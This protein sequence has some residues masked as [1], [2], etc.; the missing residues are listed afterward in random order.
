MEVKLLVLTIAKY[1]NAIMKKIFLILFTFTS[2]FS[3]GQFGSNPT[4]GNANWNSHFLG[5]IT[6]DRGIVAGTFTDTTAVNAITAPANIKG[7]PFIIV[8][9]SS[10]GKM[11]RRNLATTM[12]VEITTGGSATVP[13]N[14]LLNATG[15][16]NIDISAY[17]QTWNWSG[18][19]LQTDGL[20]LK[21]LKTANNGNGIGHSLFKVY[22]EGG[23]TTGF[24]TTVAAIITAKGFDVTN[25][26][27]YGLIVGAYHG[28][29]PGT[30]IAAKFVA[31]PAGGSTAYAVLVPADSG[32]VHIGGIGA[33]NNLYL[34]GLF[35]YQDGTQAAGYVLTSDL[36]G[37]ASWQPV[38]AADRF[39]VEDNIATQDR[40]FTG[41]AGTY[42]FEISEVKD[43]TLEANRVWLQA[44]GA[45]N[46]FRM[47][48]DSISF[49]LEKGKLSIDSLRRT[50][51]MTNMQ[52]VIRDSVG[53]GVYGIPVTALGLQAPWSM[54]A[55][56]S[57]PNANGATFSANVL[58]LQ[59]ASTSFGG[60]VNTTTQSFSGAKTFTN[61]I[62][63]AAGGAY[64]SGLLKT[65]LAS[66]IVDAGDFNS[67]GNGTWFRT[68]DGNN[69]GYFDNDA[70]TAFFGFN[71][72]VPTA[73]VDVVGSIKA[74]SLTGTDEKVVTADGTGTLL[75]ALTSP[76]GMKRVKWA[77]GNGNGTTLGQ[78]GWTVNAIG[79]AT[80]INV[81][82]TNRYT[83]SPGLEFLV[84][85]A[86]TNAIAGFRETATQNFIGGS[87]GD[88]GFTF[89]CRFGPATGVATATTRMFTGVGSS[90]AAP[91]DVEPSSI[92]NQIGVGWDA[93]DAN[94]QFM[95][96]D[97]SGTANK[98]D[99]GIPVPT[100]DR[101]SLYELRM[102]IQPNSS[103]V[104]YT[105]VDLAQGGAVVTGS[106]STDMP[107][108]NTLLAAKGW[109]SV[110]GTNSVIGYKLNSIW[111]ES[112]F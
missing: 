54:G 94:I 73:A 90:A 83:Q 68:D 95:T 8:N 17:Q 71:K 49:V 22:H 51:S 50:S 91:T 70:H 105:L 64:P 23:N 103:T 77:V 61:N 13:I 69:L 39:A 15:T 46:Q 79:T 36:D 108:A 66:G 88:G 65:V 9:T 107:A 92:V 62:V 6:G 52:I 74:S 25:G 55:I 43:L 80:T 101:T 28:S 34:G 86:A 84:T 57:S 11:W 1:K 93:A 100:V 56:G 48:G 96:N 104:T 63:A 14:T 110:G 44:T 27:T 10:D 59:P 89:I 112:N 37:F 30:N 53:D 35:Q 81:S 42:D 18:A 38:A 98:T 40:L 32:D 47:E 24:D 3:F 72:K 76:N 78:V 41:N 58:T 2:L 99:L 97:G 67:D 5:A 75:R 29:N 106:T 4:Q 21:H 7:V 82:T 87:A 60:L 26:F 20:V 85:V 111:V 16:N 33:T 45:T 109:M 31:S 102:V 12:W 19:M